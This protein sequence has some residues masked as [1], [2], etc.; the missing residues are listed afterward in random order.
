[1]SPK[2]IPKSVRSELLSVTK[3]ANFTGS[4]VIPFYDC[5]L[6]KTNSGFF[7]ESGK[8]IDHIIQLSE[9][10]SNCISNL[11]V[12]CPSCYSVKINRLFYFKEDNENIEQPLKKR[13]N[14]I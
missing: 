11:Q 4:N 1:M 10:G 9:G 14:S 13:R 7:D 3:C 6:W 8:Q 5:P 2:I 12:L